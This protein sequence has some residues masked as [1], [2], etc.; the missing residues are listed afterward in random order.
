MNKKLVFICTNDMHCAVAG[1]DDHLG[2]DGVAGLARQLRSEYGAENVCLVDAGDALGVGVAGCV[3]GGEV[4]LKL[5]ESCGYAAYCPGNADVSLG[6]S[7][8]VELAHNTSIPFVCCNMHDVTTG[9]LL[10][11]P[12][13]V[14]E[15]GG[16]PIGFVGV[17]TPLCHAGTEAADFANPGKAVGLDCC[18]EE[19]G[20]RLARAVQAAAD[21]A[22]R[23]GAKVVVLL[24][25]LGQSGEHPAFRSDTVLA[26]VRGIDLVVDGHSHES[27]LQHVQDAEGRLVP[28]VQGGLEFARASV[29]VLDEHATLLA[30]HAVSRGDVKLD[31]NMSHKITCAM[32]PYR[33]MFSQA[34]C[35]L[36]VGL[37]ARDEDGSWLVRRAETNLGDLVADA[38]RACFDA[39]IAL[40]PSWVLRDD[41]HSGIVTVEDVYRVHPLGHS[42][43][44]VRA[45]PTQVIA[46]LDKSTSQQPAGYR[47]WLQLSQGLEVRFDPANRKSVEIRLNGKPIEAEAEYTIAGLDFMVA[48]GGSGYPCFAGSEVVSKSSTPVVEAIAAYLRSLSPAE[49]AGHYN[50]PLGGAGRVRQALLL[51]SEGRRP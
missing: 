47:Y 31:D 17:T 10:F 51:K 13:I 21:D 49:V 45:A 8:L 39:D 3:S 7:R 24:S 5:M 44:C 12:Y 20:H 28:V 4:P 16:V 32:E 23:A 50:N 29:V 11:A 22:R 27:Y 19:G 6:V 30:M 9:E 43:C 37:R 15:V 2:L 38:V 34:I 35:E 18:Q 42:T 14:H 1:D 40:I 46:A 36:P 33:P 25:H 26:A 48:G 41:L